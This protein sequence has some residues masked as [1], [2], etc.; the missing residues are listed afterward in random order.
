MKVEAFRNYLVSIL[1][2]QNALMFPLCKH[3]ETLLFERRETVVVFLENS[4]LKGSG[5]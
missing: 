1:V 2:S 4:F 3:C 5:G